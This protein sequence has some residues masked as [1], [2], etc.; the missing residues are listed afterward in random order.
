L[1]E[2]PANVITPEYAKKEA[3]RATIQKQVYNAVKIGKVFDQASL[4]KWFKVR[5]SAARGASKEDDIK[6]ALTSLKVVPF[7]VYKKLADA[8]HEPT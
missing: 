7:Q 6:L 2:S 5:L 8:N 1:A 3:I 4:E